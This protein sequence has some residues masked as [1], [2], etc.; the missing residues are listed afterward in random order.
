M[1]IIAL[2]IPR[3]VWLGAVTLGLFAAESLFADIYSR[4]VVPQALIPITEPGATIC[5][6]LLGAALLVMRERRRE[7]AL[8]HVR[9]QAEVAVLRGIGPLFVTVRDDLRTG[10]AQLANERTRLGSGGSSPR[11]D[12]A[13]D[14][15]AAVTRQLDTL[16][17]ARPA[18]AEVPVTNRPVLDEPELLASD[19]ERR[20]LASTAHSGASTI[21]GLAVIMALFWLLALR[22]DLAAPGLLPFAG[23][24]IV[25]LSILIYLITTRRQP[26]EKAVHLLMLLLVSVMVTVGSL[27]Q[28]QYLRLGRPYAPFLIHKMSMVLLGLLPTRR[29][30]PT[31]VLI[32]ATAGV[33]LSLYFRMHL[34]AHRDL[35]SLAEPWVTVVFMAIGLAAAAMR[36][37]RILASLRLLRAEAALAAL[38]RRALMFLAL[39]DQLNSPLQTLLLWA[40]QLE[41]QGSS[42]DVMR[43]HAGIERLIGR[44]Q[45]LVDLDQLIPGRASS[46]S[47]DAERELRRQPTT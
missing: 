40:D 31:V 35:I 20:L 6:A 36:E 2:V 34:D 45:E 16:I 15:L 47:L 10:L 21:A 7:L 13:V 23:A 42:N 46:G 27:T 4:Q 11:I 28:A 38:H 25:S 32:I 39:R 30:W 24:A 44:S 17:A 12:R 43:V 29:A 14:R 18:S 37:Q 41:G 19:A 9:V 33:A 22:R 8:R 5:F 26:S 1:V 3:F